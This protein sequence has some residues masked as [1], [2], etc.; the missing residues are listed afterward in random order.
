MMNDSLGRTLD[1]NFLGLKK[2]NIYADVFV[3]YTYDL[4]YV[5]CKFQLFGRLH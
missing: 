1:T 4:I 5:G 3:F 2:N